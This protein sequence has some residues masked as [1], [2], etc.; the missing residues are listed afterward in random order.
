MILP[1]SWVMIAAICS[2]R[3]RSRA[4]V[5]WRIA[6]RFS[7]SIARHSGQARSDAAS[8]SSISAGVASGSSAMV[9]PVAGLMTA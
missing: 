1:C 4:A 3:S 8:A 2:A 7:T 9:P 5:L 6:A